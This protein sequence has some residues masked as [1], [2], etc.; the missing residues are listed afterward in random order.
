MST[1]FLA[2]KAS[3]M[4]LSTGSLSFIR[5]NMKMPYDVAFVPKN[6]RNA[7]PIGGAS[8]VMFAGQIEEQQEGRLE[9]HQVAD[10]DRE[11]GRVEPLHRL[12]RAAQVGLRHSP[13]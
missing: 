2:G 12:F 10:R 7:V 13:R 11:A 6:V 1:A 5:E 3:M 9:V 8:L 4:L